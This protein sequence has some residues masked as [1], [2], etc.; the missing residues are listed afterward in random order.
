MELISN[1]PLE[2]MLNDFRRLEEYPDRILI[3]SITEVYNKAA[4]HELT[5]RA[6]ETAV[7][8]FALNNVSFFCLKKEC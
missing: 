3:A 7:V 2:T 6:E 1:R 5:E 4:W 8:H